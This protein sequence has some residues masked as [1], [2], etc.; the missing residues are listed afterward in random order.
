MDSFLIWVVIAAC[1][2]IYATVIFIKA[3]K[4]KEPFLKGLKHWIV[5]I[6]DTLSGG[7]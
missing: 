6:I 2:F 7:G 4:K 5:N 1:F 3:L